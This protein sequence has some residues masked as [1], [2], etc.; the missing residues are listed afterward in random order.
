MVYIRRDTNGWIDFHCINRLGL[1]FLLPYKYV[2]YYEQI[3][4]ELV[5]VNKEEIIKNGLLAIDLTI[6]EFF[7]AEEYGNKY[8]ALSKWDR[9]ALAIAKTRNMKL[10]TGDMPL[11]KAALKENVM[12]LGTIGILDELYKLRLI[13]KE[14][15]AYCLEALIEKNG[16]I[17]RLPLVELE[18]RL[19]ELRQ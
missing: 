7:L 4:R 14:E 8:L 13:N 5:T 3:D 6:E 9:I 15:L 12:V 18:K 11:R 2:M 10:L 17:V 19:K 1:P 16:C